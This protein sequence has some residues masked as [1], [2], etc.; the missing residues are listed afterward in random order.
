VLVLTF[1]KFFVSGGLTLTIPLLLLDRKVSLADI[2]FVISI[3]PLVFLF[4]RL[5][6]SYCADRAGWSRFFMIAALFA[7]LSSFL[8]FIANSV[9]TFLLGKVAQG[10]EDSAYWAVNRTATYSLSPKRE[11][12]EATRMRAVMYVSI[13]SGSAA[14]GV[15]IFLAGFSSTLILIAGA[16]AV[17]TI[18]AWLLWKSGKNFP[19][20]ISSSLAR[21]KHRNRKFWICSLIMV[22][23]SLA[24]YPLVYLALPIF[25]SQQLGYN[26][27]S[28]GIAFMLFNLTYGLVT[29]MALKP[30]LGKK[31]VVLQIFI[32]LL[33]AFPMTVAG[34]Y[35]P[36]FLLM[37]ASAYGLGIGFF[38]YII[39]KATKDS[40]EV[41]L[42]IGVLSIP[43]RIAEFAS[44]ISAGFIIQ[45]FGYFPVFASSGVF[46]AAFSLSALYLIKKSIK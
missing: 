13:A 14:A 43:T 18:P 27:V 7:T 45:S 28:I 37:L 19:K 21:T 32:M 10:T 4:V 1:L 39:V 38:E 15:G 9:F 24:S 26:Y 12:K 16:S 36:A 33:A 6:F 11:Q 23:Y 5:L 22:F 34:F 31:R 25:M 44:V 35:F 30:N 3:L 29:F 8:Y 40:A 46:F 17:M 2:G 41:S 20:R 42:D